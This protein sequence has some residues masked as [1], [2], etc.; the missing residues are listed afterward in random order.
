[1]TTALRVLPASS[2]TRADS[3]RVVL[4]INDAL[5]PWIEVIAIAD[6][7]IASAQRIA[8]AAAAGSRAAVINEA[9]RLAF[10]ATACRT[11]ARERVAGIESP[12]G[13]A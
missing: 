7:A 12:R 1:M 4:P 9:N 2:G 8:M 6:D 11:E 5:A 10:R 13:A 3:A